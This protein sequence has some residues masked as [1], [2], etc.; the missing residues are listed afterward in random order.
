MANYVSL[1][2]SRRNLL[3]NS[4]PTGPIDK[5]ETASLTIRVRSSR[6]LAALEKQLL[7]QS[8]LPLEKRNHLSREEFAQQYGAGAADL[9]LIERLAQEHDLMVVHRS[10]AERSIVL[11]GSLGDLL[12]AFPARPP[13]V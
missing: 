6:D 13:D 3:P 2:G 10:A 5:S 8:K 4:R 12:A 9:D 7:E 11:K 1:P